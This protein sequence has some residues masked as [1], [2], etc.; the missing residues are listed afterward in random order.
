MMRDNAIELGFT[1]KRNEFLRWLF[2]RNFKIVAL[3]IAIPSYFIY[4]GVFQN[5]DMV[6]C[7]VAAATLLWVLWGNWSASRTKWKVALYFDKEVQGDWVWSH[8][9]F[10][11][12]EALDCIAR[13]N[14]VLPLS[15]FGFRDEPMKNMT[16]HTAEHGLATVSSL[17]KFVK[18]DAITLQNAKEACEDL[19]AMQRRLENAHDVAANFCLIFHADSINGMEVDKRKGHF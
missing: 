13:R 7:S 11:N 16:W 6:L 12:C 17:L 19:E 4:V 18:N 3:V 10:Q 9:L 15:H 5:G 8:A 1:H 14:N 2:W